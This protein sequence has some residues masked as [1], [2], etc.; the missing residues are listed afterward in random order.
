MLAMQSNLAANAR[1]PWN[2][3]LEAS[4]A[5]EKESA[6]AHTGRILVADDQRDVLEAL[7][8]LLKADGYEVETAT[9]PR[10]VVERLR[11]AE[12]DAIIMDL[13][14]TLDTTSGTEGMDLLAAV[15]DIDPG[16]PVVVM[17]AW[18]TID[19]AIEAMRRGACDFIQKPW[20]NAQVL[21]T[22]RSHT[23]RR[24]AEVRESRWREGEMQDARSVQ[25][26]MLRREFPECAGLEVAVW[27]Q[28]AREI[29]G[30]YYDVIKIDESRVALVIADVCGKGIPAALTMS[31]LQGTVRSLV[32]AETSPASLCRKLNQLLNVSML[33]DRFV[34][35]F[36]GI[37]DIHSGRMVFCNAGHPPPLGVFQSG[38]IIRLQAGGAV[39]GHF[40]DWQYEEGEIVLDRGDSVVL[41][42]D[43]IVDAHDAGY[44]DF[45]ESGIVACIQTGADA[46]SMRHAIT[47]A[48]RQHCREQFEDDATLMAVRRKA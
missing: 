8:M 5:P 28:T 9:V 26:A 12:F 37:L 41:F 14:Y 4:G 36:C 22:V 7:R 20:N 30:D 18:A 10:M 6:E 48:V 11:S 15:K 47:S 13:N 19:I 43:G 29:G 46:H 27:S 23:S 16:I 45:G 24:R 21:A 44:S 35:L 39:L 1:Q 40:E 3:A 34:S 17:T 42:T 2:T 31:S 38:N 25:Q 33:E 32:A